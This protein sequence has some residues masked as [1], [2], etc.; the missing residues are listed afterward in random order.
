MV[1]LPSFTDYLIATV[2]MALQTVLIVFISTIWLCPFEAFKSLYF[3]YLHHL[4]DSYVRLLRRKSTKIF[5]I[6]KK[7]FHQPGQPLCNKIP[8]KKKV[9]LTNA[10]I[11]VSSSGACLI[12][13]EKKYTVKKTAKLCLCTESLFSI[14][15]KSNIICN[16][17]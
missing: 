7:N 4:S 1:C 8:T 5:L 9:I 13:T 2:T 14:H 12:N 6:F 16:T 10:I 11:V 3:Y 17:L 15:N